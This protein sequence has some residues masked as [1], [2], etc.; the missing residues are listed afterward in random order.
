MN[1]ALTI[2]CYKTGV[3]PLLAL[4]RTQVLKA[5]CLVAPVPPLPLS[6]TARS[7][8][9]ALACSGKKHC[10]YHQR[11]A[12]PQKYSRISSI[13]AFEDDTCNPTDAEIKLNRKIML[14][15][16]VEGQLQLYKSVK[17][18]V[19]N[20]NRVAFLFNI[21]KI[22]GKDRSQQQILEHEKELAKHGKSSTYIDLLDDIAN[23]MSKCESRHLANVMWALGKIEERDH[24]LHLVCKQEILQQTMSSFNYAEICQI[25][26]GCANLQV[27]AQ[28]IFSRFQDVILAGNL[29]NNH[30]EDQSIS[31]IL[32]SYAK[33][34]S[35]NK[36]LFDHFLKEVVSRNLMVSNR[37][38]ADIVWS[39]AKKG[40]FDD[41]LFNLVQGEIIRRGALDF[42]NADIVKILWAFSRAGKGTKQLYYLFDSALVSRGL[43][44]FLSGE[45]VETVWSFAKAK[46][47]NAKVFDLSEKEILSRGMD[48]LRT[49]ELVLF[50]YS[51]TFALREDVNISFIEK[52]EAELCLR[53]ASEFD[54]GALCQVTWSLAK[55]GIS[56]SKLF[57]LAEQQVL[58]CDLQKVSNS[59]KLMVMRGF[60]NAQKTSKELFQ[61]LY[62]SIST[63]NL[64]NLTEAQI[65]E[66]VWC[67]SLANVEV[68]SLFNFLEKEI[69]DRQKYHFSR[70]QLNFLKKGF[71]RVGKGS[72]EL[73]KVLS[74]Y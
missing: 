18:S 14:T 64:S 33:T 71:L 23:V 42:N 59:E 60:I 32:L 6:K 63:S 26:N 12:V 40:I 21:A 15:M 72:K 29:S 46:M 1:K 9:S 54:I 3:H 41:D 61:F 24:R 2:G 38:I 8:Y 50:L 48:R 66:F 30:L 47:K 4:T 20:V 70:K 56:E 51:F 69:L 31:G 43:K 65:C 10:M 22:I 57:G 39:F 5:V 27:K 67:F 17:K 19:N 74:P 68:D 37:V 49:H 16:T 7:V 52:I 55:A 44:T 58:K 13:L 53:N 62:S 25:V 36:E 28:E 35:G 45:L 73:Y 11:K 34:N